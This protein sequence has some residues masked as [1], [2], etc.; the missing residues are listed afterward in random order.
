MASSSTWV[1]WVYAIII[2]A[3]LFHM[4]CGRE[5]FHDTSM[6]YLANEWERG[7]SENYPRTW[8]CTRGKKKGCSK[9]GCGCSKK[10]RYWWDW[11]RNGQKLVRP[12]SDVMWHDQPDRYQGIKHHRKQGCSL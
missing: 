10:N 1:P 11:K 6:S 5:R 2:V 4:S 9:K 8:G 3:F 12:W 7:N